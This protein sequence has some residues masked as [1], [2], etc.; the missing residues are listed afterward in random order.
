MRS[1]SSPAASVFSSSRSK[2]RLAPF[3]RSEPRVE[4][5]VSECVVG[6]CGRIELELKDFA[7]RTVLSVQKTESERLR[8]PV[9]IRIHRNSYGHWF[10]AAAL[11]MD[12]PSRSRQPI[13]VN[14]RSRLS[15]PSA[16]HLL[17]A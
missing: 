10:S 17:S 6:K 1:Q 14:R 2:A 11:A 5:Q 13:F 9:P 12:L 3:V 7:A 4:L 16:A 8:K 15:Q